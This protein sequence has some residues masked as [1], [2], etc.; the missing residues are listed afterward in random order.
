MIIIDPKDVVYLSVVVAVCSSNF[1]T[2]I[3]DRRKV[4]ME[5]EGSGFKAV[6]E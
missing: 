4:S 5:T 1:C 3:S 6:S 2:F